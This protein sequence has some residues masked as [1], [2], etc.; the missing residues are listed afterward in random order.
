MIYDRY[1]QKYGMFDLHDIL[2]NR[3]KNGLSVNENQHHG[4]TGIT[5][6]HK[7]KSDKITGDN[8]YCRVLIII[9]LERLK[10]I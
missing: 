2:V 8:D 9:R 10:Y 3:L 4:I 1:F 5:V 6:N 7:K